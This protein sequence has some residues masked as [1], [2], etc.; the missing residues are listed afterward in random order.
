MVNQSYE[1]VGVVDNICS[2]VTFQGQN[3]DFTKQEIWIKEDSEK[4]PQT[5]PFEF[6]NRN[7][8]KLDN[9]KIGDL[10]CVSFR[11]NGKVADT[12]KGQFCFGSHVAWN[13]AVVEAGKKPNTQDSQSFEK[14]PHDVNA[15]FSDASHS[16]LK[17]EEDSSG[18]PF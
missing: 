1:F 2:P 16:D 10:V 17:P 8:P 15:M 12:Q 5:I 4:Y 14:D 18:L 6:Q 7:L 13:I 11:L 3:G 9:V